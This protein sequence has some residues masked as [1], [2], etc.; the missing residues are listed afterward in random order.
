MDIYERIKELCKNE[1]IS[2][3]TMT[4]KLGIVYSSYYSSQ[5]AKRFPNVS[6]LV[7]IAKY[8]NVSLD[9]LIT[10]KDSTNDFCEFWPLLTKLK[11]LSN[12]QKS[13]LISSLLYQI[14]LLKKDNA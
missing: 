4:E 9:Y 10:G 1:G 13:L 7:S 14:K 2:V 5:Q 11:S 6:D 8:F 12:E 3:K